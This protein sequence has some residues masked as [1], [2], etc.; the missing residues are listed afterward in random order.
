[1]LTGAL[2]VERPAAIGE[3]FSEQAPLV[4]NFG[5][6]GIQKNTQLMNVLVGRLAEVVH[7]RLQANKKGEVLVVYCLSVIRNAQSEPGGDGAN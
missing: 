7:E 1:M 4:Y 5:H 2:L 6:T 3:G